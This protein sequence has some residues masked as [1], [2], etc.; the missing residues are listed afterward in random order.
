MSELNCLCCAVVDQSSVG[1]VEQWGKYLYTAQPG[2]HFFNCLLGTA[3]RGTLSMRVQQLDVKCETKT[4][5][6]HYGSAAL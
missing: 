4:K 3:L 2:L 6:L 1:I 5:V